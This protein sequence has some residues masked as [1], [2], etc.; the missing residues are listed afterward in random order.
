MRKWVNISKINVL[1]L[2]VSLF[3]GANLFAQKGVKPQMYSSNPRLKKSSIDW[4][5]NRLELIAGGG[6]CLFLGDLGGGEGPSQPLILDFNPTSTRYSVSVGARYFLHPNHAVRGLV[7]YAR[8]TAADSLTSYPNRKYRNLSFKSPIME[9]SA[10]Y[11]FHFLKPEILHFAG[12]RT[13]KL[14]NGNRIGSY[15]YVGLSLFYF[16]PKSKLNGDW[17]ALAPLNTEGQGLPGGPKDYKRLGVAIPMGWGSYILLSHNF[18]LGID[19]GVRW[20]FTDY[21]DDVSGYYYDNDIIEQEYGKVAAYFANPSV[22]LDVPDD[23]WYTVDQPRGGSLSNDTY[24]YVQV[25]LSK[26]LGPSVSNKKFKPKK[27]RKNKSGMY[28]KTKTRHGKRKVKS[29]SLNFRNGPKKRKSG[30][31]F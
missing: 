29:P 18:K 10:Q 3:L 12:A 23:N 30:I 4:K 7:N 6:P 21:I 1:S 24:M 31:S 25:T 2:L 17:Y 8:V 19:V 22:A 11:E 5:V 26:S 16:N 28:R 27:R 15:T 9:I 20:T 14:F 13:T